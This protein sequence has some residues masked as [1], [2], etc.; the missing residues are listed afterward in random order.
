MQTT[1]DV[2]II[3]GGIIGL[4][5]AVELKLK[6]RRLQVTVL[7][8]DFAEGASQAAAGML[9]PHAEQIAPGPML[10]LCLASRWRYGEWVGKLEQLTGMEA[11]YNPCGILS[12]VF[13]PPNGSSP[14]QTNAPWLDRQTID[15]YQPGLGEDV[16]GGWWHPDDGQVDNRKLVSALGQAAQSL[17]VQIHEG[18]NVQAI[19]QRHGQVT[20]V[21]TD[22]GLFPGGHLR[23]SQ[24]F[25]G[26]RIAT[27][28]GIPR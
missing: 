17:G 3:G 11:G 27:P 1:S 19:A 15:Y 25:L 23:F 7:S 16:V 18:V 28:P 20:E 8:R 12:P 26:Q 2:L 6:Q 22:Q 9:A 10:E 13:D 24:W 14:S 5:I 4:A 21:L